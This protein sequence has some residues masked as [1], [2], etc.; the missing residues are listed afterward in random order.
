MDVDINWLTPSLAMGACVPED[1]I[2]WVARKL[3]I[4]Q[5]VDLRAEVAIDPIIWT[6][7]G[8]RFLALPTKDHQPIDPELLDEGVRTVLAALEEDICTLVHCQ[9]GIGRSALLAC[10]VL[11]A[12]GHDPCEA[13]TIAKHA[14]PIVSPHP[15]QLHA[16][17]AYAEKH[18]NDR[19]RRPSKATWHDLAAIAY[20]A[21]SRIGAG[22]SDQ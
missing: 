16:L 15:D 19:G 11:V 10:C 14:R 22:S 21:K 20:A 7:H 17:L 3:K 18:C 6:S 9:F 12:L 1:A 5:V 2:E 8:V 4:G 13:I